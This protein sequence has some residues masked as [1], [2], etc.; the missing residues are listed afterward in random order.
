MRKVQ[1]R[2][3]KILL[4]LLTGL[5]TAGCSRGK[6]EQTEKKEVPVINIGISE[7][8]GLSGDLEQVNERLGDLTEEKIG[9]RAQLVWLGLNS[10]D[11][12]SY[13]KSRQLDVDIVNVYFNKYDDARK[14]IFC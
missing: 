14:K 12:S 7:R 3:A 9:V 6:A 8:T 2:T 11:G 10:S 1:S 13:Y 5:L 4:L